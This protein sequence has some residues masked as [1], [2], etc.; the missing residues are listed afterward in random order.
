MSTQ[1]PCQ[2]LGERSPRTVPRVF[3]GPDYTQSEDKQEI[4]D[5][6]LHVTTVI[7]TVHILQSFLV[8]ME[9]SP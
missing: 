1:K 2:N 4:Q 9:I 6:G 7:S 8:S 5:D 3:S